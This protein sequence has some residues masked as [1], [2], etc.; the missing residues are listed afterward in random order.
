MPTRA[1]QPA[2]SP[3]KDSV[4]LVIREGAPGRRVLAVLR[5]PDDEDLPDVWGLPA[6]SLRAGESWEAAVRRAAREKLRVE[7]EPGHVLGE[8]RAERPRFTLRMRLY[9]ARI[10]SGRPR[11][12]GAR[13]GTTR[14]VAWAWAEPSALEPA[15]ER[16]SLCARLFL[17]AGG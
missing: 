6:A 2:T 14:Y 7:V 3:V 9:E 5:P 13:A 12:G 15:A 8:G 11:I 10:A 16:G 17:D 1:S 4:A